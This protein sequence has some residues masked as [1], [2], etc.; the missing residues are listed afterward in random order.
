MPLTVSQCTYCYNKA[1]RKYNCVAQN[2]IMGKEYQN[3]NLKF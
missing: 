1:A 2:N 3:S